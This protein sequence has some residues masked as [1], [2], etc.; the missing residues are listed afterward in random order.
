VSGMGPQALFIGSP[1][2]RLLAVMYPPEQATRRGGVLI[3]PPFAE[4]MNKS[5]RMAHE[6]AR[7][8][9]GQGYAVALVDLFGTGDSDGSFAEA[10]WS[11]WVADVVLA[12]KWCGERG[13][14]LIGMI[15]IRL[16]CILAAEAAPKLPTPL[17]RLVFWQPA[18][19]GERI[20][21]QFLRLRVA[22]SMMTPGAKETVKDLRQRLAAGETQ[23]VAG[24]QL[25]TALA[26]GIA[27]ASLLASI[28]T[29]SGSIEWLEIVR[30]SKPPPLPTARALESA[31]AAGARVRYQQ[32]MGEP[33]W[34]STE[35]VVVPA[36]I[37]KTTELFREAA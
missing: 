21:E 31:Q 19:D 15:G 29:S 22:A 9:N 23:E 6:V 25:S 33:F 34:A 18:L 20:V 16:G 4:E 30:E 1:G 32:I 2:E 3:V 35:I 36:L 27:S 37:E 13:Y 8:L 7:S 28:A 14:P 12:A 24:Y 5:R 26:Q 17:Q 11:R 10:T